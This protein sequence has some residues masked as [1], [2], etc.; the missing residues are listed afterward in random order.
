M[1]EPPPHASSLHRHAWPSSCSTA[2]L[3]RRAPP[4][5]STATTR[6]R[7]SDKVKIQHKRRLTALF[8]GRGCESVAYLMLKPACMSTA[9]TSV[10]RE[11]FTDTLLFVSTISRLFQSSAHLRL[12]AFS[13]ST[14]VQHTG[15][16]PASTPHG[17]TYVKLECILEVARLID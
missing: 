6:K 11:A 3:H 8:W 5:C 17:S 16:L 15:K 1:L 7:P 2:E 14:V 10:S 4:P 13:E 9:T 12:S